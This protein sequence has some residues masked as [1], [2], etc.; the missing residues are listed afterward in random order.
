VSAAAIIGGYQQL[1]ARAHERGL[2]IFGGTI[3]PFRNDTFGFYTPEREATR[4]AVNAWIRT[5]G[6]YDAVI[7]FDAALRDPAHPG[8]LLPIYD[9]G[10]HLHPNDAGAAALANAVPLRIFR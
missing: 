2:K 5:S 4:Q 7:D 6:E 3:L 1:I 10:D 9:S 8:Q